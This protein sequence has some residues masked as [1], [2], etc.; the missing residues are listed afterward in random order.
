MENVTI[1]GT[2]IAGLTAAIYAARADLKPLVIGGPEDGGQ[3]TL[4]TEVDNFPGFAEGI[5]GPKLVEESRKQ[6]ERFGAK[7]S[8]E[9]ATGFKQENGHFEIELGN[10]EKIQT[11]AVIIATGAT[12]KW[13]GLASE[14]KYKGRGIHTCATCDAFFYKDKE[15]LVVGGGD[16][17]MEESKTIAKFA[18]KVAVIH[19]RDTLRASKIMQ[20]EF[21]KNP[22]CSVIWDS[23]ITE[24]IGDEKKVT[25]VKIKNFKT[26]EEKIAR[27][28]GVFLA[29]G[30]I[31]NTGIFKGKIELDELGYVKTDRYTKTNMPGVFAAGDVQ[32]TRYKQAV[33]AA[34]TGCQAALEAEKYIEEIN[35]KA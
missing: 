31:P 7:F 27:Y 32:D 11:K 6:A 22:K 1:L 19:R 10:G 15:V 35:R 34:G 26:G 4:T 9:T 2:G 33:T 30:H 20:D 3:L 12:A 29:I 17:A 8:L 28:D 25:S 23:V 18:S 21:F 13:L 24:L 16:S 14:Q 5:L